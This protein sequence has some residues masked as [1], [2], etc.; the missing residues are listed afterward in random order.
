M[1]QIVK[2][3]KTEPWDLPSDS[4]EEEPHG[5]IDLTKFRNAYVI[6]KIKKDIKSNIE[7]NRLRKEE[8]EKSMAMKKSKI[9][10]PVK[11]KPQKKIDGMSAEELHEKMKKEK[12][13][14]KA[15]KI[16]HLKRAFAG[17][18]KTQYQDQNHLF[19]SVDR[20]T[21]YRVFSQEPSGTEVGRYN[22]NP[23]SN[24]SPSYKIQD[25]K[26]FDTK[27][28]SPSIKYANSARCK[29]FAP[30]PQHAENPVVNCQKLD[31]KLE[32]FKNQI[33]NSG[34]RKMSIRK[35]LSPK[36]K[37]MAKVIESRGSI[38]QESMTLE[39]SI[40]SLSKSKERCSRTR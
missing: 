35:S 32:R 11:K 26:P 28:R 22:P 12:A 14:K 38:Q 17:I 18:D 29:D 37:A 36:S 5:K 40:S 27:T 16:R 19:K 13:E 15:A 7:E 1:T 6:V 23:V 31:L 33:V 24:R 39:G 3:C 4:E 9:V 34:K 2:M 8:H 10:V 20:D 25:F 21:A 30:R